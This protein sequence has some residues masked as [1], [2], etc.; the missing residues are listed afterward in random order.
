MSGGYRSDDATRE[1]RLRQLR[2]EVSEA[3]SRLAKDRE[4]LADLAE[5]IG[6]L[7]GG[8][9]APSPAPSQ[10]RREDAR[11]SRAPL[12]VLWTV[13]LTACGAV[14]LASLGLSSPAPPRTAAPS[15]LAAIA[16]APH[17]VDPSALLPRAQ[18][19]ATPGARLSGFQASYVASDGTLDLDAPEGHGHSSLEITFVIA[20]PPVEVD[21][22]APLGGPK[23]QGQPYRGSK[24]RL[25]GSGFHADH[26]EGGGFMI[27]PFATTAVP[28][29]RCTT[30][31]VWD[32]AK[33]AGA[34]V[35]AVAQ[36]TYRASYLDKNP[37]WELKIE[38]TKYAYTI[39]DPECRV[40]TAMESLQR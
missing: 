16:G 34:P 17:H 18:A 8:G 28:A 21:P 33:L 5:R 36:L 26:R 23:P 15:P 25:D 4:L 12:I 22:S 40:L 1:E 20:P 24:V 14:V 32:A 19:L 11:S 39:G 3:E 7:E 9:P 10:P 2:A 37:V 27:F 31:Q 29:P 38:D 35:N 13:G 6:T 30:R